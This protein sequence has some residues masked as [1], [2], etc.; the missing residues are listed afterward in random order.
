[1]EGWRRGTSCGWRTVPRVASHGFTPSRSTESA[2]PL[3][4]TTM[5]TDGTASDRKLPAVR[6]DQL[7]EA[8]VS[9]ALAYLAARRMKLETAADD[10]AAFAELYR[11]CQPLL[12]ALAKAAGPTV[13]HGRRPPP[14]FVASFRRERGE[15]RSQ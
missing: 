10:E 3:D 2:Y 7:D 12:T 6:A 1:M 5:E 14:R 13:L 15:S 9:R 11:A 4:P 8:T